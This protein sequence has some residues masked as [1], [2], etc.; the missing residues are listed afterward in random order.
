M[1]F[2]DEFFIKRSCD[3]VGQDQFGHRY[4]VARNKNGTQK[5]R[6]Y[7]IYKGIK[8]PSKVPP[9]WHG[10]LHYLTDTVPLNSKDNDYEWQ[11]KPLPNLTGTKNA[12]LSLNAHDKAQ[13][14][15]LEDYTP[16]K[17]N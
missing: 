14:R 1:S 7:V 10:W 12:Y 6:R 5:P 11:K 2:I 16:W 13:V 4:F 3:F 9:M 8:E 15:A 17:P